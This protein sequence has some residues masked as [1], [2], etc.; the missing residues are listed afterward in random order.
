MTAL[1]NPNT[2][3]TVD[4]PD[5]GVEAV[6]RAAGFTD[7]AAPKPVARRQARAKSEN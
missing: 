7:P 1:V 6:L 3:K 4:V 5:S 2:G